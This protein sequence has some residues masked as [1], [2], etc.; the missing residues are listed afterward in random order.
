MVTKEEWDELD[1]K[2]EAWAKWRLE[3]AARKARAAAQLVRDD[4][5][6]EPEDLRKPTTI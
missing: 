2:V 6:V 5:K 1:R 3:E 4:A